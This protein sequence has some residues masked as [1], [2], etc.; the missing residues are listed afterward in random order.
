[1]Y[2][3]PRLAKAIMD[4]RYTITAISLPTLSLRCPLTSVTAHISRN[5]SFLT[6]P[7]AALA[8][9][10][11]VKSGSF[12]GNVCWVP[13]LQQSRSIPEPACR[14]CSPRRDS[15]SPSC[16]ALKTGFVVSAL[17]QL[18]LRWQDPTLAHRHRLFLVILAKGSQD[19]A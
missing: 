3:F 14:D 13:E 2:T 11:H 15:A 9:N 10:A 18:L 5:S 16:L 17:Q 1:M 4:T 19:G 7:S 12:T 8:G 6:F